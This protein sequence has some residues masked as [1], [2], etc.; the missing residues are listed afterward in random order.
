MRAL[1]IEKIRGEAA[2]SGAGERADAIEE[3]LARP[4]G[5]T[6]ARDLARVAAG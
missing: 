6:P 2:A 4:A 3:I 5:E 1:V